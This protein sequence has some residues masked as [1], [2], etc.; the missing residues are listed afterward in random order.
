MDDNIN[1]HYINE[2]LRALLPKRSEL[3][4]SIE[5]SSVLEESYVPIIEPEV[6]QLLKLIIDITKP[7]KILEV[8]TAVGYSAIYMA[9]CSEN[10]KITTIERYKSASDRARV[11]VEKA[12]LSDRIQIIEG[13]ASDILTQLSGE[14]DMIFLD[15]AKGQYP[16]FLPHL[17]KLLKKGGVLVSD[18]VLYKGMIASKELV[19]RRKITIVKRLRMYLKT[20][21]ES[22]I[23]TTSI[24]PMG[25]GVAISYKK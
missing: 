23:F 11:N 6:A 1:R 24:I 22:E 25:D 21:M 14:Y 12:G 10:I 4:T 13:D 7:Q 18:N 20:L 16:A 8:G 15:A 19:I 5:E 9:E 3:L 17:E 2:Y